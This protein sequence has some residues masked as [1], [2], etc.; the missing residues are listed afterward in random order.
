MIGP[1]RVTKQ[2]VIRINSAPIVCRLCHAAVP[3][4]LPG[5]IASAKPFRERTRRGDERADRGAA[6]DA[7]RRVRH[8]RAGDPTGLTTPTAS[9]RARATDVG[10]DQALRAGA[11]RDAARAGGGHGAARST[12]SPSRASDGMSQ[13]SREQLFT[14]LSLA[15][16]GG[17]RR[18]RRARRADA[19]VHLR[20]TSIPQTGRNPF[21]ATLGYPGPISAPPR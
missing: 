17:R 5:A 20:Q 4:D 1:I 16:A 8:R 10:A 15:S 13:L 3:A 12:R 21:W 14:N 2:D 9:G 18:R 19:D 7:A 11:R 6:Q